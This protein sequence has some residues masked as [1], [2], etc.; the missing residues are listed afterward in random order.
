MSTIELEKYVLYTGIREFDVLIKRFK[1]AL[2]EGCLMEA[3]VIAEDIVRTLRGMKKT[4][5]RLHE[6]R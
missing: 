1:R 6:R 4:I 5:L 3:Y 2:D